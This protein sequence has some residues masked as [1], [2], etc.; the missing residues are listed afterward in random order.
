MPLPSNSTPIYTL[1]IPST[2]KLVKYRPFLVKEEKS[3]LIAQQSEDLNVMVDTLKQIIKACT[4]NEVD[5]DQ[6]AVFDLEYIFTQ[7][8]AKSVGEEVQLIFKCGHCNDPNAKQEVS[9]DISKL[10][11]EKNPNHS[12]TIELDSNFGVIMKYPSIDTLKI[13]DDDSLTDIEQIFKVIC[14]SIE[15]IYNGD[16]LFYTKDETE[17][18]VETFVNNLSRIQFEKIK[19]FFDTMPKLKQTIEFDCPVCG[20]HNKTEL[21]GIQSFF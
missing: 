10:S 16:D 8:R 15:T 14:Q 3:L 6:L 5:P 2:N 19:A 1:T 18:E 13:L 11:V 7:I 9:I 20:T 4:N 21:E 17:E 12:K